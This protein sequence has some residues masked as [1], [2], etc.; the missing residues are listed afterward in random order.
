MEALRQATQGSIKLS[1]GLE[2]TFIERARRLILRIS[3]RSVIFS[4][5]TKLKPSI[6]QVFSNLCLFLQ[7]Y[8]RISP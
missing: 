6:Q 4:N 1:L 3:L 2:L 8:G 5:A 7:G